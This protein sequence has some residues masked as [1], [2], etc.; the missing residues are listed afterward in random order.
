VSEKWVLRIFEPKRV[1]W[2]KSR[3]DYIVRSFIIKLYVSPNIIR[4]IKLRMMRWTGHITCK[5]LVRKPE[6][7]RPVRR[8]RHG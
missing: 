4:V 2:W 1:K 7:K 8:P 3:E 5:I 6:G